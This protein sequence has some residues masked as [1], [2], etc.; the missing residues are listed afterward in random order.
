M[1]VNWPPPCPHCGNARTGGTGEW[2]GYYVCPQT[3]KPEWSPIGN[4]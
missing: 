3:G 1:P 4:E 2:K